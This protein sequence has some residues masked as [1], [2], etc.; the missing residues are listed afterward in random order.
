MRRRWIAGFTLIELVMVILLL[1]I[2]AAVAIPNFQ[3]FRNEARDATVRGSLGGIRSAV[4]VAR[5]AISLKEDVGVPLYPTI[6]E[7]QGNT[8]F[9]SHPILNALA[10]ANKRILDGSAGMPVNPWSLATI[11]V[12][13][14]NSVYDCATVSKSFVRSAAGEVDFGWCYNPTTGEFWANSDRN[15]GTAGNTENAF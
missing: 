13:Q 2:L 15:G 10:T 12:N 14:Q 6:L 5:A 4:A 7:M 9:G 1:A 8:Y 3:D 11:P